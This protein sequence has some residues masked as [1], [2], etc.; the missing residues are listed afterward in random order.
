MSINDLWYKNAVI[1]CLDVEKYQDGNGDGIGDFEGLIRRLD[2]LQGLG[3]TCVWLQPFYRSPFRDNGYDVA[4]YYS[5]HEKHGSLG[6]FVEFMNRAD[7]LGIRVIVDL[8]VNHTSV[9]CPWFKHA[10]ADRG[11]FFRDWYVWADERPKNHKEGIVFPGKQKTTW[12]FDRTAGQYY[13]HRFYDH[14]P[15]LNTFNP[16]VR[17]EIQKI[18]GFW[19]QLGVSGFRLDAVPF[20]IQKKGPGVDWDQDFT[21]LKEMRDFLQWR[22]GEAVL[23]AEANVPPAESMKY[24]GPEGERIQMMLDFPVN[25]RLFY[26]LATADLEPLIRTLEETRERPVNA[27]WVQFL[28]SHDELDL[29]RLTEEQRQKVFDAFGP[30]RRMQLYNRGIRRRLT[31]MLHNNRR[32]LEL[33]FSLLFSLPGTPMM[34]YGD[35]IGMGDNLR[36]P[37]R[38]CART[39]M[40]WTSDRNG[41][42]SHAKHVVRPVIND[43]TYGYRHVNVADERRDP[44]SLLNWTERLIRM[45][46]E[47]PEISWGTFVVLRT[48]VPEVL[49]LRYDWRNTSLI[50]VHNFSS[51][52]QKV[53]LKAACER[54]ALLVDVFDDGDSRVRSDGMHHIDLVEYGWKWYRVG[55]ADNALDRSDLSLL[56]KAQGV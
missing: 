10:R 44:Q 43:R 23:L 49:A 17:Q 9:D 31:P 42:F 55:A 54:D 53:L 48:T 38:E 36:L 14:Q 41:G 12:T 45:R 4:D 5:V 51:K 47:C 34:Q 21:L 56:P 7:A 32:R 3:V 13:F 22:S 1:Y 11:S 19:L 18:M 50:T 39:P 28:R 30:D 15:D 25:Q 20:L 29:G 24:F 27:Q 8:V 26:A 35:E 40:Q 6:D 46:K 37:E 33:A 16:Y 52:A 2:Y